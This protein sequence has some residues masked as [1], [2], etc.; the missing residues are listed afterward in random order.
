[1]VIFYS[2]LYVLPEGNSQRTLGGQL[3]VWGACR[4]RGGTSQGGGLVAGP[5]KQCYQATN[6]EL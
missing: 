2:F 1:M 6:R 5:D 3:W 4:R